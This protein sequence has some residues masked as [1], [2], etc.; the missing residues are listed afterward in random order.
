MSEKITPSSPESKKEA[1]AEATFVKNQ[2]RELKKLRANRPSSSGYEDL[3]RRLLRV[4]E[5]QA[6]SV[7]PDDLDPLIENINDVIVEHLDKEVQAAVAETDT[8]IAKQ[9]IVSVEVRLSK[10]KGPIE[11]HMSQIG[12]PDKKQSS[13]L[14]LDENDK[15]AILGTAENLSDSLYG[16]PT[17]VA[18]D[19]AFNLAD[20]PPEIDQARLMYLIDRMQHVIDGRGVLGF[21]RYDELQEILGQLEKAG[22]QAKLHGQLTEMVA[23][24]PSVE[25]ENLFADVLPRAKFWQE[26]ESVPKEE[27]AVRMSDRGLRDAFT[28]TFYQWRDRKSLTEESRELNAMRE[29]QLHNAFGTVRAEGLVHTEYPDVPPLA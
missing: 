17:D 12:N 14:K 4:Y 18:Q 16:I 9:K 19:P 28:E 2:S 26:K 10:L 24:I 21:H 5:R 1:S 27:T 11:A 20:L 29:R 3:S 22:T 13:R 15:K 23:R 6:A 7:T 8:A 25:M